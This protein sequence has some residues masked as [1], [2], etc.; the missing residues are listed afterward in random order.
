MLGS[1]L[2]CEGVTSGLDG[3]VGCD[4]VK[5]CFWPL[6]KDGLHCISDQRRWP[7]TCHANMAILALLF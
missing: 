6:W 2:G 3:G 1:A 4:E 7:G 5:P